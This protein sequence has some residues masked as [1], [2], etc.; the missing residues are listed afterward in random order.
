[1]KLTRRRLASTL[2]IPAAAALAQTAQTPPALPRNPDEEL[3]A[4]RDRTKAIGD[5][6]AQQAVPMATEPALQFRA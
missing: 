6:L 2:L 1:M 5:V 3:K 4:A